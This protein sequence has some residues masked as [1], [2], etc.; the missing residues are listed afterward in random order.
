MKP[1]VQVPKWDEFM[2]LVLREMSNGKSYKRT[3][4]FDILK[5]RFPLNL[6]TEL[7]ASGGNKMLNRIGWAFTHLT[8]AEFVEKSTSIKVAIL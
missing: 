8:K 7:M 3:E 6:Q 2:I 5:R 1:E 4:M